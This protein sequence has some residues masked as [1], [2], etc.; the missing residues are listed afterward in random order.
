MWNQ[1]NFINK[2]LIEICCRGLSLIGEV[3]KKSTGESEAPFGPHQRLVG[4][5][6]ESRLSREERR[7]QQDEQCVDG[8]GVDAVGRISID[9]EFCENK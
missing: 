4:L 9:L 3:K 8:L 1:R 5:H 2:Y 7:R 6:L